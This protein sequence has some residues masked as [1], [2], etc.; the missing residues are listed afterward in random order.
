MKHWRKF[1]SHWENWLGLLLFLVFLA[2]AIF[3]PIISPQDKKN[4]GVFKQVGLASDFTPYP[5]TDKAILGTLPKQYDVFHT[6][7]WGMRDA[8]R[9]GL[10]VALG[11]FLIGA[12]FGSVSAYAGGFLNS[13]M[14]RIADAFLTFPPLAGVVFLQQLIITSITALG[15]SYFFEPGLY[16]KSIFFEREPT[17][18]VAFMSKIDPVMISLIL[19]SWVPYARLVNSIALTLKR[20]DF[21][22]A[23]R[24][25][26]GSPFWI[27]RRHLLPN[28]IG[29]AIVLGARDVG[30]MVILQATI[31]YL[32]LGGASP[33]GTL[34]SM[35]RNFVLGPGGNLLAYWW[36]FLPATL[37]VIL[38]GISWN[39]IGDGLNDILTPGSQVG[40]RARLSSSKLTEQDNQQAIKN[41]LPISARPALPQAEIPFEPKVSQVKYP[42]R[43][44]ALGNGVDPVLSEAREKIA[45]GDL[46]RALHA[47]NHMI[48]HDR[49]IKE[50]LPDLAQL[51][52]NYPRDPW[53]WQTLGD[54]LTRAGDS[55]HA[56]EAYAR[57]RKLIQ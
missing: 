31:T 41:A 40:F 22:Q 20:T 44:S 2:G 11:S 53:V 54:A 37:A 17:P 50:I 28:S 46:P 3:A 25:L 12:L 23:A 29:P 5:P 7:V 45:R 30:S 42:E 34:L 6:L 38:F 57:A 18:L 21:V 51:V 1:F 15:G 49:A 55:D 33:W 39:L 48:R 14:M 43:R 32:G 47:Y 19:F 8:M 27:I 36:V 4:P 24:A 35:G 56:A 10:L 16:G 9:F 13:L 52:K 26:G